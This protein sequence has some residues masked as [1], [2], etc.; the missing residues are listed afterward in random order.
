MTNTSERLVSVRPA[1][2][3]S[4]LSALLIEAT[5]VIEHDYADPQLSPDTLAGRLHVSRRQLYRAFRT[6]GVGVAQA[7]AEA[8]ISAACSWLAEDYRLPLPEVA[9]RSGFSDCDSLRRHL[10]RRFRCS[11]SQFR[12]KMARL[13]E[14][15]CRS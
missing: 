9:L 15:D 1:D 5:R 10:R 3:S 13:I 8:R 12:A 7:I 4:P 2:A 14:S 6:C 11:P